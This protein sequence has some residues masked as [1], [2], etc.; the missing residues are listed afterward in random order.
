MSDEI[1]IRRAVTG[2]AAELQM[3]MHSAYSIY[4]HRMGNTRLPPMDLDYADEIENYP[5][6]VAILEGKVVGGITMVFDEDHAAIANVAV[7]PTAQGVGL[8]RTLLEFAEA[9]AA[10]KRYTEL[11]LATHVLLT[12]NVDLYHH[13]GWSEF[14]R[15]EARVFMKKE[16][17]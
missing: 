5:T 14:D 3:C 13:L 6:W 4:Q 12:E 8:G 1:G 2:D 11:R 16:I 10:E 7:S 9:K 15:D 17:G